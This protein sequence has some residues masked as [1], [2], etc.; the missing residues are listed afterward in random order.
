MSREIFVFGSNRQGYHGAGAALHARRHHGAIYGKGEGLMGNSYAIPTREQDPSN[1]RKML[2]LP[3]LEI[4][5][6]VATFIY[7]ADAHPEL[8][9]R[10]TALGTGLAGYRASQIAPM[11]A[12]AGDNVILP[13]EFTQVLKARRP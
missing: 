12:P 9:F 4:N 7:F 3:L 11:F 6:H 1:R 13:D 8:T 10:V 2:T 5:R